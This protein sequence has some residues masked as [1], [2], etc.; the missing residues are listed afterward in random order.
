M[1]V[2]VCVD[3]LSVSKQVCPIGRGRSLGRTSGFHPSD[4]HISKSQ[5]TCK[6]NCLLCM[7]HVTACHMLPLHVTCCRC[8]SHVV[9]AHHMLSLHVTCCRCMPHVVTACH[10]LSL[11]VAFAALL[12]LSWV[13][14]GPRWRPTTIDAWLEWLASKLPSVTP[15]RYDP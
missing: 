10:M 5:L 9:T 2:W 1:C 3:L 13:V 6:S 15:P 7:S 11:H 8:M 14:C 4:C 12:M